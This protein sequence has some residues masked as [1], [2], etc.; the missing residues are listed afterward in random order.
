LELRRAL[1]GNRQVEEMTRVK[2][3][4]RTFLQSP[5]ATFWLSG[6]NGWVKAEYTKKASTKVL[7]Q[8]GTILAVS[9]D[10]VPE[11]REMRKTKKQS[12]NWMVGS[13]V[14]A[15]LVVTV[16]AAASHK[17]YV[18]ANK[19]ALNAY[20]SEAHNDSVA[21]AN[22]TASYRDVISR[23]SW[24]AMTDYPNVCPDTT[25]WEARISAILDRYGDEGLPELCR[26]DPDRVKPSG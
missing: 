8:T 16:P 26:E 23:A 2:G 24:R 14:L 15:A 4:R 1:D 9:L 12:S 11:V 22:G 5:C 6:G 3:A 25:A 13:I 19:L 21:L 10:D 7:A 18:S 17:S 20:C